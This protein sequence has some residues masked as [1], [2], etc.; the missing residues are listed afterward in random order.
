L[1]KNGQQAG[2]SFCVETNLAGRGFIR[3]IDDWH[4]HGYTT[5][6]IF[7]ALDSP[8][9]AVARVAARVAS[10][11]HGVAEDVVRRRWSAGL[12]V[13]FNL[14][15]PIVDRWVL[16]D[17]S[18]VNLRNVAQRTWGSPQASVFDSARGAYFRSLAP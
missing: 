6:L 2:E 7:V 9:L 8:D 1:W 18:D 16:I 15:L 13:L 17:S 12:P 3:W 11:G 4:R 14:Y 10:G 5:R